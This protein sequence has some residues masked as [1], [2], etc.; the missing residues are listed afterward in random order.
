MNTNRYWAT[1]ILPLITEIDCIEV[2]NRKA[3]LKEA[4]L[5]D[6]HHMPPDFTGRSCKVS[7]ALIVYGAKRC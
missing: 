6:T 7:K 3:S 5:F 1:L 4:F 2:S